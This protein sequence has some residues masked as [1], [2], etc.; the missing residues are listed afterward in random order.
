MMEPATR[1][2][3]RRRSGRVASVLPQLI[4]TEVSQMRSG[5][6]AVLAAL[7]TLSSQTSVAYVRPTLVRAVTSQG[8]LEGESLG[9]VM[10]F[11]GIPYAAPPIGNLRFQPPQPPK[12]WTGVR[13]ALDMGPACPQLIDADPT[14]NNDSV[15]AEDC[16][17]LNVWTPRTDAGK[18]PVMLWIHG[19]AF[20]VGS[21]RNTFYDGANLAARG[22][23]VVVSINY[24]LGA[25][26]FLSL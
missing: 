11:R 14:E 12:S 1:C 20:V 13:A 6:L 5:F 15:M 2:I 16:L 25:W 18:R 24:R 21:A 4:G 22:D 7:A 23:M 8:T 3:T 10:V 9:N 19:G 26:G 17:S